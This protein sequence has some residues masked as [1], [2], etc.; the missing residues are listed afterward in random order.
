[1]YTA[2]F[3]SPFVHFLFQRKKHLRVVRSAMKAIAAPSYTIP[4]KNLTITLSVSEASQLTDTQKRYEWTCSKNYSFSTLFLIERL[5]IT[6]V[7]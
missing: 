1:M 2:L 6:Y 5:S 7:C 4:A 3:T